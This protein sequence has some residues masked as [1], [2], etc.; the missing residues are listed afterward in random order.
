MNY[1]QS[2]R[3]RPVKEYSLQTDP[4]RVCLELANQADVPKNGGR[5]GGS[6]HE[7]LVKLPFIRWL[8]LVG[9]LLLVGLQ[10]VQPPP[11]VFA[12][13]PSP[14]TE[15]FP[16]WESSQTQESTFLQP[17]LSGDF[18]WLDV[19]DQPYSASY[20]TVYDYSDAQV[21]LNYPTITPYFQGTL[22]AQNLKPNFVYQVK[23]EGI[24]GA[25]EN[26]C[27]GLSGRWWEEEWNG[28]AW[29]NGKNL[30]DKGD[31]TAPNPND[32]VY[33]SHRDLSSAGH[34]QTFFL[35]EEDSF[36]YWS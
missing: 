32:E 9:A 28:S 33:F 25:S 11:S 27:I 24:S 15:F 13:A 23:L 22:V 4:K 36:L 34:I 18:R 29:I 3:Q 17:V 31:G 8:A 7:M 5:G 14:D 19:A 16:I 10:P 26:E 20:R 1:S 35:P 12:D 2:S 30:N 6:L 21:E